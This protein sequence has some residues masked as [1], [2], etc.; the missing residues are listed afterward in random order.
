MGN[1]VEEPHENKNWTVDSSSLIDGYAADPLSNTLWFHVDP[2][3]TFTSTSPGDGVSAADDE[4]PGW[5]QVIT[6]TVS[7]YTVTGGGKT[8]VVPQAPFWANTSGLNLTNSQVT[9]CISTLGNPNTLYALPNF[10]GVP[11]SDSLPL[12]TQ[13]PLSGAQVCQ[14]S[15][16]ASL[17]TPQSYSAAFGLK[18]TTLYPNIVGALHMGVDFFA[19]AGSSVYSIADNGI[20]VGIGRGMFNGGPNDP[21]RYNENNRLQNIS[22]GT[23]WGAAYIEDTEATIYGYKYGYN[24]I[25][26]YGSLYVLYGHL[27][28]LDPAMYVG[29][30]VAA[31]DRLGAIGVVNTA[32]LHFE[33]RNMGGN[34]VQTDNMLIRVSKNPTQPPLTY[35]TRNKFG[36]LRLGTSQGYANVYDITQFYHAGVQTWG[37]DNDEGLGL[38][39]VSG[40]G[41]N[42]QPSTSQSGPLSSAITIGVGCAITYYSNNNPYVPIIPATP[43]GY[44]GFWLLANPT[45]QAPSISL[46]PSVQITPPSA[47]PQ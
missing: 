39:A 16:L 47:Y 33:V 22:S 9:N 8:I 19:A 26:R 36:I 5:V 20:V 42:L 14:N 2:P 18:S 10:S 6:S 46:P 7:A 23:A 37:Q 28:S 13:M 45:T 40:L 32:H 38:L 44:R 27:I 12:F 35:D 1:P 43:P 21:T 11:W 17:P 4:W 34:S 41:F 31:G 24:M 15:S 25:V 29:R 30:R 3:S